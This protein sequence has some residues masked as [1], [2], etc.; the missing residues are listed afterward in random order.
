L[1]A[2]Q[3]VQLLTIMKTTA[4]DM[5]GTEDNRTTGLRRA[6]QSLR[7]PVVF[8]GLLIVMMPA[9]KGSCGS[10][11]YRKGQPVSG[12]PMG[13]M[14][15][16]SPVAAT[17][18]DEQPFEHK[19]SGPDCRRSASPRGPAPLPAPVDF[20]RFSKSSMLGGKQDRADASIETMRHP[21][22]E[23]G[24]FFEPQSVFRPPA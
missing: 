1:H 15:A 4:R 11:L 14:I 2:D 16:A 22:S 8:V 6:M 13:S 7:G 5:S 20:G 17:A 12:H 3:H 24:A 19:C 21:A 23:R 18:G 10:Y 9:A